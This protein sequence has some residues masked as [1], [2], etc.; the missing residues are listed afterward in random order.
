MSALVTH[1]LV[2]AQHLVARLLV[3]AIVRQRCQCGQHRDKSAIVHLLDQLPEI[4]LDLN[5][6]LATHDIHRADVYN[7]LRHLRQLDML[8]A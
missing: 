2:E 5:Q 4:M 1:E 3:V 8:Q 7:D 6:R